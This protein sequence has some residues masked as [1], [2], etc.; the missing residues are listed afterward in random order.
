MVTMCTS[1][2]ILGCFITLLSGKMFVYW[3]CSIYK[4]LF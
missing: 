1:S 4:C 2:V 3:H